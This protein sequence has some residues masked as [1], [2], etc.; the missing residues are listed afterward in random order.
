MEDD[1]G[2]AKMEGSFTSKEG[3][4]FFIFIVVKQSFQAFFK[5]RFEP[6]QIFQNQNQKYFIHPEGNVLIFMSQHNLDNGPKKCQR[7]FQSRC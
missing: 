1:S 3:K 7:L 5:I 4:I 6:M 2:T